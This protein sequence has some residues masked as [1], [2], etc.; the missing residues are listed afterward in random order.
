MFGM[1]D[2]DAPAAAA[3]GRRAV[4]ATWLL[5]LSAMVFAMV[6][7]GGLT[8]LTHSGLSIVEWKP[9]TGWLPPLGEEA[10]QEE[11][12]KYRQFPEYRA[13]NLGMTVAEFKGIYWLEYVHRLWGRIIAL[14]FLLPFAFFVWRGWAAGGLAAKLA[15]IFLLGAGQGAFGWFMVTSGLVDEP[16]VSHYR[17]TAHLALALAVYAAMLWLALDLL[18]PGPASPPQAPPPRLVPL[19]GLLAFSVFLTALSGGLVAGLDAGFVYNTFPLMDGALLPAGLYDMDPPLM[20]AFEDVGTV[21]FNH[22]WLAFATLALAW[23]LWRR[24]RKAPLA[25]FPRLCVEAAAALTALQV[26]LG[27]LTLLLAVP[28]A[29]AAAHQANA[30]LAL[31]AALAAAHRLRRGRPDP[32]PAVA[33]PAENPG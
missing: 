5:L 28:L 9:L 21:Q 19:A 24:A 10:W 32:S 20:S 17:L 2:A 8:R 22:R 6:V 3:G 15:L 12:R 13:R 11:F 4:I 14:A 26:A 33:A 23:L 16:D 29:L 7:I 27:V 18:P 30:M 25:R 1:S 31:A